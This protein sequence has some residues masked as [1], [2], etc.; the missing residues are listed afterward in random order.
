M[1]RAGHLEVFEGDVSE[2]KKLQFGS[3]EMVFEGF[4]RFWKSM[5][6]IP[7]QF[8]GCVKVLGRLWKVV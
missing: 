6:E 7:K 4:G 1:G 5:K 2:A 3:R 8:E